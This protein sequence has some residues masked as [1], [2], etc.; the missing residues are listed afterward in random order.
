MRYSDGMSAPSQLGPRALGGAPLVVGVAARPET[1]R[2]DPARLGAACDVLEVRLD[3]IGA[4]AE[5]WLREAPAPARRDPP[6]LL[7]LRSVR[8]GGRYEGSEAERAARYAA[9]LPLADAVDVELE[10]ADLAAACAAARALRRCAIGSFHDFSGTPPAARLRALLERGR[11]AGADLVKIAAWTA[12][13]ADIARLEE[14]LA[15][16]RA[17]GPLAVMGMGPLGAVSRMRL[18]AAGSSLVY[19]FLDDPTALGQPSGAD[20]VRALSDAFPAYRAARAA[21][22]AG[23]G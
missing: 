13:D 16:A 21:R 2:A 14:L 3:L 8:E 15:A 7:T 12:S 23:P 20:L 17:E 19:G 9:L 4:E 18:A 1:L 10:S 6:V 11:R 22:G 5:R